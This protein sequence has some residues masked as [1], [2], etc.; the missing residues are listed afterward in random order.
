MTTVA[1]H[2]T[3]VKRNDPVD[4][5]FQLGV[6]Y[7]R[8]LLARDGRYDPLARLSADEWQAIGHDADL[9]LAEVGRANG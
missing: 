1:T 8:Y 2:S 9:A 3:T 7:T 4:R 5:A 6:T